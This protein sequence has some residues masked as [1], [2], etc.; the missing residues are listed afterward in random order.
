MRWTILFALISVRAVAVTANPLVPL[1][2]TIRA[3]VDSKRGMDTMARVYSTDRWFTFPKFEETARYLKERL[4]QTGVKQVEIGGA[5]ADGKSQAG[6]WT[7]PL[8]WD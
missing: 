6:F 8:A 4:E 1:T 3:Q 5:P 7:M 2:G